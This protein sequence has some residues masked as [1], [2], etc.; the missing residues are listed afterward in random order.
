[1]V[2]GLLETVRKKYADFLPVFD[3]MKAQ[4]RK[5]KGDSGQQDQYKIQTED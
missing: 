2:L 5:N 1:M 4:I 3:A